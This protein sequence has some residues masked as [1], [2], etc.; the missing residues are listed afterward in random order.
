[1]RIVIVEDEVAIREGLANM[2]NQ[3]TSHVV[4]AKCQDGK[5]GMDAI[6]RLEPDCVI[7]DIRMS[8]MSG[9]EMLTKLH[10]QEAMPPSIIISG[11]SEFEYAREGIRLGIEEYLLKPISIEALEKALE[12]IEA[13]LA[14]K[15]FR[16]DLSENYLLAYLFGDETE[17]KDAGEKLMKK[18]PEDE[19]AY[20]IFAGYFGNVKNEIEKLEHTLRHLKRQ[21]PGYAYLDAAESRMKIRI[22]IVKASKEAVREFA[23]EFERLIVKDEM[24]N[25]YEIPW[26]AEFCDGMHDLRDT[27]LLVQK[28]LSDSIAKDCHRLIYAKED[29]K[30]EKK[31]LAYPLHIEKKILAALGI[32]DKEQTKALL[33]E[34]YAYVLCEEYD[35]GDIRQTLLKLMTGML[36]TAK[37][38]NQ[39]AYEVLRAKNDMQR[40]L[41]AHTRMEIE[42]IFG[43][44]GEKIC[45]KEKRGGISNYTINRTV[46][47]IRI[48]YK[49]GISLEQA[50]EALNI[51]P[52]YLSMLFKREMGMNFSVFLK[53]F[54][55][56]H[57]KRLLKETDMKVYEVAEACGY[58]NSNYFTK[59]FKEVTGISPADYR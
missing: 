16:G 13:K 36:D 58:N 12:K 5:E 42:E 46:E 55:I 50:A 35:A 47:Y 23:M 44:M 56:S 11:Y 7:T 9:L 29:S 25:K 40:V 32:G 26:A 52:E 49:E 59:V 24:I 38:I 3:N 54:R 30:K 21:Y 6:L 2:I 57:A 37:E 20:G 48:H 51:T 28:A 27:F 33:E 39:K 31:S 22:L 1:M 45:E 34:F 53:E 14:D 19:D 8:R 18:F 43:R 17:Q 10:A 41:M 15:I 4:V